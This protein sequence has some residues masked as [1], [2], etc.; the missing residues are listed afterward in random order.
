MLTSLGLHQHPDPARLNVPGLA[1]H[2]SFPIPR[3]LPSGVP[4]LINAPQRGCGLFGCGKRSPGPCVRSQGPGSCSVTNLCDLGGRGGVQ[5][6][7][8]G[9]FLELQEEGK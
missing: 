4:S 5:E 1:P 7:S 6:A 9:G 8:R 3:L 2:L